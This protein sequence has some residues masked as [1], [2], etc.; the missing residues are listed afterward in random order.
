MRYELEPT[1]T[2]ERKAK[3]WEKKW[4]GRLAAVLASLD[5]YQ[6][7]LG[8]VKNPGQVKIGATHTEGK[9]VIAIDQGGSQNLQETRLY[10]YPEPEEQ[11]I[12]L[13]TIGNKR[14]QKDDIKYAHDFVKRLKEKKGK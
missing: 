13:L 11:V 12:W 3:K 1:E 2:F 14:T 9:G 6:L 5:R 10:I 4:P 8:S 7:V